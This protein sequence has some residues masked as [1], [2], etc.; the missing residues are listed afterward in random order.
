MTFQVCQT[1]ARTSALDLVP[2]YDLAPGKVCQK[3]A[4]A[5]L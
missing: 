1:L 5:S 3:Q 4:V 2:E